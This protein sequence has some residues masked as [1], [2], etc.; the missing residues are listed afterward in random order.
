MSSIL[1]L[2][3][4]AISAM[5]QTPT[6]QILGVVLDSSGLGVPE[7]RIQVIHDATGQRVETKSN[8]TGDY[9]VP[10]VTPGEYTVNAE[11]EGFKKSVRRGITVT[12]FQNVRVDLTL[13][14]GAVTQSV[15]VEGDAP[16]VDTR[17]ATVG[18]LVDDKRIV[19]LPLNGRNILSFASLIPGVTRTSIT[20]ASEVSFSQQR[21]NINGSRATATNM[22]LDGGS[23]YYAHRGQSLNMP[24]PDAVQEIKVI[25]SGVTAEYGRGSAV[26]AAVT[27]AGTNEFHGSAWNFLRNDK[28]D[29]RR[30]FDRSKA[31]LRYNQ[32]GATFGGPILRNKLFFFASYQGIRTRAESSSTSAFPPTAQ[33]RAG[34]FSGSNPAPVD[35]LNNQAFPGRQIPV[36]RFDPV[37]VKFMSEK[38]PLP[39]VANGSLAVLSPNNTTGDNLLGRFDW[40]PRDRDRISYRYFYDFQRGVTAFPV[41]VSPGSNIPGFDAPSTTDTNTH[42]VTHT[43]TWSSNLLST[44]RGSWTK[45]VY[46]ESN[47]YRKTLTEFGAVNFPD[48]GEPSPPRPPQIVVNGRF[49]ASPGKDRQRQGPTLDFAQDWSLMKGSH[50]LKWGAQV[51]R[52]GYSSSNNSASSGRFVFDG[53]F[54][55]NNV[56]DYLLGRVVSFT[57]N[58]Y[59]ITGGQYYLPG[60]YFQDNWKATRRLTLNLGLRMELYSPWREDKGQMAMYIAGVQSKTFP[61]APRGMVYQTDP[62]YSYGYD[63]RNFGPRIGFAWDVTGDGKTSVRGGYAVSY[64]GIHSE[65]LLSGNQPFSLSVEYRNGGP[66][67]NPYQGLRNPFPYVVDPSNAKFDLPASIGGHLYSPFQAAYIQNLSFTV[68]RQLTRTWM[69][70]VGFVGNYGRKLPLQV[71]FNPARYIAG[72]DASGRA[73]STT[74]NTD[75]R[76][77]LAPT[78]RG[79]F[80]SSWDS[81]SSYNGLQFL[82]NKRLADGFTLVAHYTWSKA[83]DDA[84]QQETLDQCR[85]QDPLNRLGSRGL[86]EYDRR[87]V[88]VFSY[89]YEVPFFKHGHAW[90][91]QTLGNWQLA[92]INT[93]QTGNPLTILTGSDVSL[94][95][96]GYDRP[97]LIGNPVL[98]N[99]RSKDEKFARWFNTAAFARNAVGTYGNAGRSIL[100]GPG[101]WA[102]DLSAQK[103]FTLWSDR[104]RLEFR[105][106]FFNILNHANLSAPQTTFNTTQSFGRITGT[107]GARV[108]QMALRMEF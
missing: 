72:T 74:G 46:D 62:E 41:V 103:R 14:V 21:I 90:L 91:R 44:T 43:R 17:T 2:L 39:N 38:I 16:L 48:A 108:L 54:S 69:A 59:A 60:F 85:Q 107:G 36:S 28:L 57:Q 75:S 67:S 56:A 30:F 83:I 88:A 18:T 61:T 64:D 70:Q 35:P 53:T 105:T 84:C 47:F 68:Q 98:S 51:Q 65:Y 32:F 34:D 87:H 11:K 40:Q 9:L 8:A 1:L 81:N 55:R 78:Y 101:S 96:V 89:L 71:E 10:G 33:E 76:R 42:T 49:S 19:D 37:A 27:K 93:F 106:D 58:S 79:F 6:G 29:A 77:G 31:K 102:W 52:H 73:L 95:G 22:Q 20:G 24:P 99:S 45:F 4:C 86:G 23:M 7:A 3:C 100:G 80:V 97:D 50:E 104:S 63:S 26:I 92:G 13:E 25:S 82:V 94:T 15:V 12:S 5:A 66:L